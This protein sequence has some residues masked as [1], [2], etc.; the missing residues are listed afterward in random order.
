MSGPNRGL[1][2]IRRQSQFIMLY[3]VGLSGEIKYEVT[4]SEHFIPEVNWSPANP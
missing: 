3:T 2:L 4:I 1:A